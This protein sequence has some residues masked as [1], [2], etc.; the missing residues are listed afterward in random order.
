MGAFVGV[1]AVVRQ[2]K[3]VDASPTSTVRHIPEGDVGINGVTRR[4]WDLWDS[5]DHIEVDLRQVSVRTIDSSGG[6]VSTDG[7]DL[8]T[9]NKYGSITMGS[10][11]VQVQSVTRMKEL[12]LDYQMYGVFND[13]H[14]TEL[15]MLLISGPLAS[16]L[17][18]VT[19]YQ[20]FNCTG[21]YLNLCMGAQILSDYVTDSA[22]KTLEITNPSANHG[23]LM[24]AQ[25]TSG[26]V[27]SKQT[28][29]RAT[30]NGRSIPVVMKNNLN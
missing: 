10:N 5:L 18:S 24:A 13:G 26:T 14:K 15:R 16:L 1:N 7:Y 28:F 2:V 21:W 30:I 25:T 6:I 20:Y 4:C 29:N 19:G 9:L 12:Q 23:Q 17:L 3:T 11:W 27:R 8:A 22:S